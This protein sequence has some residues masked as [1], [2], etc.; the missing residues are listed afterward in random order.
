MTEFLALAFAS[1]AISFTI[2]WTSI[3]RAFREMVSKI[4]PKVDELIHCPWCL[5]HYVVLA[6]ILHTRR[7]DGITDLVLTWFAAVCVGGLIHF[8]LLRAYDPVPKKMAERI[9][10]NLRQNADKRSKS[11]SSM[12]ENSEYGK[13]TFRDAPNL[14][15]DD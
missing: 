1:A 5:N 7:Y 2:S 14:R 13:V 6:I 3:F 12:L 9:I 10:H 11:I 8:V 15:G 4:H